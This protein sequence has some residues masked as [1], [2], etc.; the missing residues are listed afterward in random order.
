MDNNNLENQILFGLLILLGGTQNFK[1]AVVFG[2]TSIAIALITRVIYL[3]IKDNMSSSANWLFLITIGFS[4]SYFLYLIIPAVFP[5]T[6]QFVNIY[7]LLTGLTPFVYSGCR[8]ENNWILFVKNKLLFIVI[9]FLTGIIR[10]LLGYGTIYNYSIFSGVPMEIV[11]G[12][13]GAFVIVGG[14][15]LMFHLV[16][17]PGYS[18][19]VNQKKEVGN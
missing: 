14:L 17:T 16:T 7:L 10:E 2:I 8:D 4:L 3:L 9:L 15:S 18:H 5:Y 12:P 19:Q 13:I 11:K 1:M 6:K